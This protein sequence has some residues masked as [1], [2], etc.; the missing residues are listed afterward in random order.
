MEKM[1]ADFI[2]KN[3]S[4]KKLLGALFKWK[5]VNK[6][7][8]LIVLIVIIIILLSGLDILKALAIIAGIIGALFIIFK[9]VLEVQG[10]RKQQEKTLRWQQSQEAYKLLYQMTQD[11]L[12]KQAFKMITLPESQYGDYTISQ[13]DIQKVLK[14]ELSDNKALY[15][16][17]CLDA[18]FNHI[19]LIANA[20]AI[21]MI[22]FEDVEHPLSAYVK[23]FS[24]NKAN[25]KKFLKK[26]ELEYL[27]N[28][29][30]SFEAWKGNK[31]TNWLKELGKEITK[32]E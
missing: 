18:L 27:V 2:K 5:N 15:I 17:E 13:E 29:F 25:Y 16:Q 23:K 24:K 26:R 14:E 32:T 11:N 3:F 21:Q 6:I 30:E 20:I 9:I 19:D 10:L 28:F 31:A 1:V 12:V 4:F 22:H 7:L 8:I